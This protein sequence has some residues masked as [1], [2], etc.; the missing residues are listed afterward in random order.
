MYLL[1]VQIPEAKWNKMYKQSLIDK[2]FL[3]FRPRYQWYETMFF[4]VENFCDKCKEQVN[5]EYLYAR[6]VQ[7]TARNNDEGLDSVKIKNTRKPSTLNC[8]RPYGE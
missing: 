5:E 2:G 3:E 6:D 7:N 4:E 8:K 1:A